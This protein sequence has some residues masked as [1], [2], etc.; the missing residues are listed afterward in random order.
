[1]LKRAI[2]I[3]LCAFLCLTFAGC[4]NEK[5]ESTGSKT[6]SGTQSVAGD[7]G[8]FD[9]DDSGNS[10]EAG[11]IYKQ[12]ITGGETDLSDINK[13]DVYTG[14]ATD[15]KGKTIL[16]QGWSTGATALTGTGILPQRANDLV[17]SI[18]KTL[19]CTIKIVDGNGGYN[20]ESFSGLAAGKPTADIIFLS[21]MDLLSNYSYNRIV[22]LDTLKVFDFSDRSSFTSATELAKLNGHYYGVAPRTYGT[23][24]FFTASCIFANLD[25]LSKS[26]ITVDDLTKWVNNKEWTWDKMKEVAEKVKKAGY[27]F[28]YDGTAAADN[29]REHSLY[30]S[31]L[32]SVGTDWVGSKD[33]TLS[34]AGDSDIA[35]KALD[36]Y[37]SMYDGGYVKQVT[38][39]IDKFGTGDSAMLCAAMYTPKFNDRSVSWGNYT[40]LPL[41]LGPGQTDYTYATG[42]YT[43]S[44]IGRGTKPSGLS[45]AE[46]ATVLNLINTS[47]ISES[48]NSSLVVSES[49][50]WAKN[51]LAQS[52]VS[53]YNN[54]NAKNNFTVTWSGMVL[55]RGGN[56]LEWVQNVF[57]FAKG[58][59][60]KQQVLAQ[61]SSYNTILNKFLDR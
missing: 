6:T 47:L 29:E 57:K 7:N 28:M 30:M 35:V 5:T 31:L 22:E 58:D 51:A 13:S 40:I 10:A 15:L 11:S 52:T 25:V 53:L 48:E 3:I 32:A 41:P 49:I 37:K 59:L 39:G 34:F 42:D 36:F 38:S 45:D 18:E 21:K 23:V 56:D 27:T 12:V 19:N 16:L 2:S 43:F 46:I 60:S 54:L 4:G 50:G 55:T 61:A 20:S 24:A 44:A 1:M 14:R 26:G 17:S 9:I 8:G 33:G